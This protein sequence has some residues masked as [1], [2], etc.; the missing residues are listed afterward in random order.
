MNNKNGS[1]SVPPSE[2]CN[3]CDF[4]RFGE[5]RCA[6]TTQER[7]YPTELTY[8]TNSEGFIAVFPASWCETKLKK[9]KSRNKSKNKPNLNSNV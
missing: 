8:F 4:L 5:K 6:L 3:G 7:P 2:T 1:F 9:T